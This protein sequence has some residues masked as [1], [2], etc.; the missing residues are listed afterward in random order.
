MRHSTLAVSATVL[1]GVG[2][3]TARLSAQPGPSDLELKSKALLS[4]QQALRARGPELEQ[5]AAGLLPSE[6]VDCGMPVVKGDSSIDPQMVKQPPKDG[7]HYTLRVIQAP[8]CPQASSL[9]PF[10]NAPR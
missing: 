3:V 1:I 9:T 4:L 7:V 8:R 2:L 6:P 5:R 10:T